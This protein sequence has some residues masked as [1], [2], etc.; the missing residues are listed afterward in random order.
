MTV[1]IA[2]DDLTVIGG[3]TS[4]AVSMDLGATGKRGSQIFISPGNPTDPLTVIG[5]T[6]EVFD[7]CINT[8]VSDSEYLYLYQYQNLGAVNQW[9]PLFKI[10][11]DT[12]ADNSSKSFSSGSAQIN[13]PVS[14]ITATQNLSSS[15]F[16]IQYSIFGDNPISSSVSVAE[17]DIIDEIE[18]LPITINAVEFIDNNWEPAS[19]TKIVSLLITVV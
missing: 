8:L 3:P 13:I 14:S 12:F 4:I 2:N 9:M 15:N 7:L 6:P 5:Q 10:I 11:P 16:N 19:G 17:I 1:L 18:V